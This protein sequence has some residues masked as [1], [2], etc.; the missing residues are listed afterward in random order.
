MEFK[1]YTLSVVD[2]IF[3]TTDCI[4]LKFKQ[5]SLRK[6][7]YKAGQYLTIILHINGRKYIRAYSLS[8]EP[9]FDTTLDISVKR[10]PGGIV[11]NYINDHIKIG[12]VIEVSEPMGNFILNP[13]TKKNNIYL[14]GVGSGITPLF[15]LLKDILIS[16]PNINVH[17]IYGNKSIS[18][19]IF[20]AQLEEIL[21]KYP[22]RL[23]LTYFYSQDQLVKENFFIKK[24]RITKEFIKD[25]F[26]SS[27]NVIWDS[28]H[29]ICGP[30][31][32][33]EII[34]NT[35]LDLN[36]HESSIYFEEFEL[37]I[38]PEDLELVENSDVTINFADQLHQ[39]FVPKG[40][41]ILDAALDYKIDLPYSC[42]TG[43]C[44]SCKSFIKVGRV[45]MIGLTKSREDLNQ[46]ETL[47]CCSYP[48]TNKLTIEI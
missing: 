22:K 11:S 28:L 32:L 6:I 15:S 46:N 35:L 27:N 21:R 40:K 7:G 29:Y 8:S 42:Q 41:S 31:K 26:A 14:W 23:F 4:T 34:R 3:E 5:P 37:V 43:N 13:D 24:G 36:I 39:I 10:I 18:S 20:R 17:L 9:K 25:Y 1:K 47:L 38:N 44:G 48:L 33:K 2:I 16:Y 45:K 19:Q 12:D 30:S